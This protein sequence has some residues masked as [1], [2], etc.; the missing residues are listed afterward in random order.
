MDRGRAASSFPRPRMTARLVRRTGLLVVLSAVLL[1]FPGA[2]RGQTPDPPKTQPAPTD[3]G[4]EVY[5]KVLRSTVWVHSDRGGGRLATGSGSLVDK[6]RRLI[7]TNYHVVGD[8]KR[9]TVFFPV[10]E[11]GKAN[12][13]KG[14]YRSHAAQLGIH[15]DVVEVDKQADLALIRLDRLPDG[16]PE[17]PLAATSPD[18]GQT[19]HSIGNPGRSDALWVYTPGKVRQVYTKKWRAKLDERTT[20]TFEAKVVE[21]DSPTNPGDSGGPLVNDRGE[22][23]G[24]TQ[25]GAIDAQL[26][27][28]FV[29]ITEVKRLL[30]RR[31][32]VALRSEGQSRD[33][34]PVKAAHDA[35]LK[36]K[37]EGK[38]FGEEAWKKA[39]A[40]AERLFKE[41]K[42]DLLIETYETPPKGDAEKVKGMAAA[43]REKFFKGL[44][45]E[46]VK[47]EKVTGVYI[48]I[49][50]NPTYLYVEVTAGSGL[51]TDLTGKLRAALLAA[52]KEKKF[53]EGL[54]KAVELVLEARGGL[55]AAPREV[56]REKPLPSKDEGKFFGE[57]AWKKATAA[58]ERLLKEKKTDL[59]IETFDK[60]PGADPDK[61]KTPADR[62]KFFKDY[63]L[64]RVK[65]ENL[66]GVYIVICRTPTYL[67]ADV[68]HDS[69][70]P[71]DLDNKIRQALLANFKEKK[72]DEG[73]SKAVELVL[74]ARGLGEKK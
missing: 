4:V 24:V 66:S 72:F 22:L 70:L 7:L 10:F 53:D 68:T 26:L 1:G 21:T 65:A 49:S 43:E 35:P 71:A 74:E 3:A 18:P 47:A 16:V 56:T 11:G 60:P 5:R 44:A 17:L 59:L 23:I 6:G 54:S 37:D 15:G 9:A 31:S 46:R 38:F 19:V 36:C 57:E 42:T 45:D 73:L 52:F 33:K 2:G 58:T 13:N 51:P 48:L 34:E 12:P 55:G 62:E 40:T 29:D 25:G 27:S 20:L 69:G 32:V 8:I 28:T 14:Y 64:A 41:K 61:L 30:S 63:A 50:K 67:Y 39:Q